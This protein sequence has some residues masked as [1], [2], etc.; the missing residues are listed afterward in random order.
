MKVFITTRG[1]IIVLLLFSLTLEKA[2]AQGFG[3]PQKGFCAH[4]GAMTTHPENTL[5]AFKQAILSGAQ[6]IELDVQFSKDSALIIMHDGTVDRTTNGQG[7]VA[8][9]TLK[10]LKRL[11]AGRWMDSSFTGTSVPTLEEAFEIMPKNIWLNVHLKGGYALGK[12]VAALIVEMGRT[13]QAVMAVQ[14]ESG[15][16]ARSVSNDILICNMERQSG[17]MDYVEGT[18]QMNANFIQ[19]KGPVTDDFKNFSGLLHRKG[20]K[21]NYFGTDDPELLGKLFSLGIDFPLVNDIVK[22]SEYSDE[23]QLTPVSPLF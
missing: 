16:G 10:E 12:K 18:I 6:M 13:H 4:R 1:V 19:L 2:I 23:F 14:A 20:I 15:K 22:A 8:S 17:G 11:D 9:L 21:V 7:E 3:M 5:P